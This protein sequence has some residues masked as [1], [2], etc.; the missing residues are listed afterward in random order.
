MVP[1]RIQPAVSS[2]PRLQDSLCL[3]AAVKAT[4]A[5]SHLPFL[6]VHGKPVFLRDVHVMPV[7]E[8]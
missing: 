5:V 7:L 1:V 8:L 4:E 3:E 2:W 6:L